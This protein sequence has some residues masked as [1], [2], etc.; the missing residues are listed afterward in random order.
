MKRN[1]EIKVRFNDDEYKVLNEKVNKSGLS[2]EKFIRKLVSGSQFKELPPIDYFRLVNECNALGNN[3]NQLTKIA[4][5]NGH[6]NS[7]VC[8]QLLEDLKQF[9]I[10]MDEEIRGD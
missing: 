7:V 3:L 5:S 1:H 6:I 2:R 4:H 10:K 9:I 8:H